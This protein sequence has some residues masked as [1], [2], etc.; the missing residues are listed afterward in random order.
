MMAHYRFHCLF[1]IT[2]RHFWARK[3]IWLTIFFFSP[4]LGAK[5]IQASLFFTPSVSK[6]PLSFVS[7][8]LLIP[9]FSPLSFH[10][11]ERLACRFGLCHA[12][13]IQI[14]KLKLY[15]LSLSHITTFPA[16]GKL[17]I[18]FFYFFYLVSSRFMVCWVIHCPCV[19]VNT[20]LVGAS[21]GALAT[22]TPHLS[23]TH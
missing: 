3:K 1:I 12:P 15:H 2:I 5:C 10:S 22:V 8:F 21:W 14:G 19:K 9:S 4:A 18:S 13:S 16:M 11:L 23:V 17:Q 20:P 7:V 6:S